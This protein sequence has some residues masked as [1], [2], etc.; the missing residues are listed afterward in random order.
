MR[1]IECQIRCDKYIY[2]KRNHIT[3]T[4]SNQSD[5]QRR[6]KKANGNIGVFLGSTVAMSLTTIFMWTTT[7]LSAGTYLAASLSGLFVG[8]LLASRQRVKTL[9]SRRSA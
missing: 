4:M 3:V 9:E 1:H 2:T 7:G 8:L 6:L 5:L